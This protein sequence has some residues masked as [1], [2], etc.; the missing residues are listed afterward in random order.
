MAAAK[1][2]VE[3]QRPTPEIP[4]RSPVSPEYQKK[5]SELMAKLKRGRKSTTL[6]DAELRRILDLPLI[7][8]FTE[9]KLDSINRQVLYA[10]WYN[11]GWRLFPEQ[12]R[13]L[14]DYDH[15]G[16]GFF[17]IGVGG[18]KTLITLK[19]AHIAY[20]NGAR[21]IMLMVPPDVF[22]QLTQH[23]ISWARQ[24]TSLGVPFHI[25]GGRSLAQREKLVLSDRPGC[26]IT[27]YSLMS[28]RDTDLILEGVAPELFIC[29]EVHYLK[30][31]NAARTRRVMSFIAKHNPQMVALSGTITNKSIM[32][33]HHL[34]RTCLAEGC[35]LPR[36]PQM[37]ED[38]G[39]IIDA[40][41]E[42]LGFDETK[43]LH[44][45]LNWAKDH[46][47]KEKF[48]MTISGFRSAYRHRLNTAPGVVSSPDTDLGVG[49]LVENTPPANAEK[50]SGFVTLQEL[51]EKVD[52]AF[53]TP[54]DDEIEHAML[55]WKWLYELTAGFYNQ[56]EWPTVEKLAKDRKWS[57]T[58]A[59]QALLRAQ[60][61]HRALQDY[62]RELRSFLQHCPPRGID[63]P[64]LVGASIYRDGSKRVGK[65]LAALWDR[66]KELEWEQMPEREKTAVR[67]CDYKIQAALSWA[68]SLKGNTGGIVWVHHKEMGKWAY[69]SLKEAGF[70]AV[71]C[72]AGKAGDARIRDVANAN[73]ICVAS[74]PGHGTG[75]NLQ[76]FHEVHFLQWPKP[77]HTAEQVLGRPHRPGQKADQVRVNCSRINEFDHILFAA[78]LNDAVYR[79]QT[80]GK[81]DKLLLASYS[82]MPKIYSSEFLH[83]QGMENKRLDKAQREM[84]QD[85]FGEQDGQQ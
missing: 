13:A 18:G 69:E 20:V 43:A 12:A 53:L 59:A 77:A 36:S 52:K 78:T 32:D 28:T 70:D 68:K 31:K 35:P 74:M 7:A 84:M 85:R 5:Q 49:L 42:Y 21:K 14:W 47:P 80:T 46:F 6:G 27:P 3:N 11:K 23:D 19:I 37:A 38:W 54:N 4:P 67:V 8:G 33:Y 45:L 61:Y 75:K 82:P 63:T 57:Q 56:L 79:S 41:A 76:H 24:R 44:P 9:D 1:R 51:M 50:V 17:P 25:L 62:R 64:M 48:P 73:K 66:C 83:E 55:K 16:G 65:V 29:D 72:P 30:N 81:R 39:M 10:E 34:I 26:Y 22:S 60:E 58:E 40:D 71:A 15:Y 2:F